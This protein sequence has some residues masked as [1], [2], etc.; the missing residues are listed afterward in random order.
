MVIRM[1]RGRAGVGLVELLI[2]IGLCVLLL[3]VAG[4]VTSAARRGFARGQDALSDAQVLAVLVSHLRS[5]LSALDFDGPVEEACI[6][7]PDGTLDLQLRVGDRLRHVQYRFSREA[8][9]L[10]R[11]DGARSEPLGQGLVTSFAVRPVMEQP[12]ADRKAPGRFRVQVEL[13]VRATGESGPAARARSV[14]MVATPLRLN[15]RLHRSD[16]WRR[17]RVL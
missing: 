15:R 2:S 1:V 12:S 11:V 8:G 6:V 16:F 9:G 13:T 3:A 7:E 14:T 17:A 4:S 5:D 10:E